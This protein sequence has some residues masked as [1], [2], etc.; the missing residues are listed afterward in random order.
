MPEL[1]NLLYYIINYGII[2]D[3]EPLYYIAGG[4]G[5]RVQKRI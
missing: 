2:V 5:I 3:T 1:N 4:Y